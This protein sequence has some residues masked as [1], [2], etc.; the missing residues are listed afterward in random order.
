LVVEEAVVFLSH[1]LLVVEVAV[2]VHL[3]QALHYL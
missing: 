1:I 2:Q 3:D